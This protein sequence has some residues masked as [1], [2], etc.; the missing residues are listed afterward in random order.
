MCVFCPGPQRPK[1]CTGSRGGPRCCREA[2]HPAGPLSG[3]LGTATGRVL[4]PL[5]SSLGSVSFMPPPRGARPSQASCW[6]SQ[7]PPS[8]W[9]AGWPVRL[10]DAHLGGWA[11]SGHQTGGLKYLP[12]NDP[13]HRVHGT[14]QGPVGAPEAVPGSPHPGPEPLTPARHG[15]QGQAARTVTSQMCTCSRPGRSRRAT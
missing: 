15:G 12:K 11:H 9:G 5:P 7:S 13:G 14:N 4:P 2:G 10:Q 6:R 8:T 3:R 1:G